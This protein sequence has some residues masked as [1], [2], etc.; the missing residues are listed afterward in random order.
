MTSLQTPA[1]KIK[2]TCNRCFGHAISVEEIE[3]GTLLVNR[4]GTAH[5]HRLTR[6]LEPVTECGITTNTR[7]WWRG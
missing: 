6:S 4:S 2:R 5:K 3:S 1:P 7:N